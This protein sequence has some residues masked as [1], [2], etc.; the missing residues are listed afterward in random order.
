MSKADQFLFFCFLLVLMAVVLA[1]EGFVFRATLSGH[2]EGLWQD[3][4]SS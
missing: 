1:T 4:D 2:T 3:Q